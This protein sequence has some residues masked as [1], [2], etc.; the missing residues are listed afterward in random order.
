MQSLSAIFLSYTNSKEIHQMNL[1][2]IDSLLKSE[3]FDDTFPLQII[4]IESNKN[5]F[6]QNYHLPDNVEVIVPNEEFNFHRFLNIGIDKSNYNFIALCNND[7]LFHKHWFTEILAISEQ[8]SN[9]L[10]YSP[11]ALNEQWKGDYKLGYHIRSHIKGW[12]IVVKK[13]LFKHIGKLDEAFDFYYAD[14]DYGMT[15]KKHKLKHA[16]VSKSIVN[17]LGGVNTETSKNEGNKHFALITNKYP[18]LPKYLYTEGYNWILKNE[19]LLDGHLKFHQ[20]WG[21]PRWIAFR[22]RLR[23]LFN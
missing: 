6:E 12:C 1:D 19:K 16:V 5:Y 9:I 8:H 21:S 22:E 11:A 4:F 13:E 14:D 2:C 20:K 23:R 3:K 17:H 15:L 10:S 7:L 18:N